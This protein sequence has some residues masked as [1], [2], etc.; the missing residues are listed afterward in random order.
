MRDVRKSQRPA[1]RLQGVVVASKP[2]EQ[3]IGGLRLLGDLP[4][5]HRFGVAEQLPIQLDRV[6]GQRLFVVGG[7]AVEQL[8]GDAA[9]DQ[10][11]PIAELHAQQVGVAGLHEPIVRQG[12]DR[13]PRD[14]I[15]QL[16]LGK[17]LRR[18]NLLPSGR[19]GLT[20]QVEQLPHGV[21]HHAA[22]AA[23]G[24]AF[25]QQMHERQ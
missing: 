23:H 20:I 24:V 4:N 21:L 15:R 16:R 13:Q 2:L 17:P 9:F 7:F 8:L 10:V 25:G 5:Q 18:G 12:N 11:V 1:G 22:D 6:G 14:D 3:A 19:L